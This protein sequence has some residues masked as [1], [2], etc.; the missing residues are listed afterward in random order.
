M[1]T[2][3]FSLTS[4]VFILLLGLSGASFGFL[5]GRS[6]QVNKVVE[7]EQIEQVTQRVQS[8]GTF[9]VRGARAIQLI[10]TK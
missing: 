9:L 2:R 6:Q 4:F 7:T 10:L 8:G 1:S 5:I 3:K